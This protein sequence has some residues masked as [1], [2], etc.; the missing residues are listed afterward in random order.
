ML[1]IKKIIKKIK[2][3]HEKNKTPAFSY[4]RVSTE[5]Q[6]KGFSLDDQKEQAEQYAKRKDLE[7]VHAFTIA[8]S[9]RKDSRKVF[10]QM[11]ELVLQLDVK[12][13]IFK[14]TDRMSRNYADL[15]KIEKMVDEQGLNVHFY[16]NDLTIN[17][18]SNHNARFVL[19]IETAVAKQLSDKISH[20]VQRSYQHRIEKGI[21]PGP[22]PFGY[23]Y[24]KEKKEYEKDSTREI[25]Q[26]IHDRFDLGDLSLSGMVE[27]LS[28]K[29]IKSPT[30]KK[31]TKGQV[32]KFLTNPTYAGKFVC[33]GIHQ[34]QHEPYISENRFQERLLR[35]QQSFV[36]ERKQA[37]HYSFSALLRCGLCDKVLTGI[38]KKEKHVYYA[39][40]H[41]DIYSY[42]QEKIWNMI[43]KFI[44]NLKM[45]KGWTEEL[46]ALVTKSLQEKSKNRECE[47]REI[48][49]KINQLEVD[50]KKILDLYLTEGI[51]LSLLKGKMSDIKQEI[52]M[53]EKRK[54]LVRVDN[55]KVTFQICDLIDTF[56][57]MPE[58]YSSGTKKEKEQ[59]IRSFFD[60]IIVYPNEVKVVW[61]KPFNYIYQVPE[62]V[63]ERHVMGAF[64]D[65]TGTIEAFI[66][67]MKSFLI[68]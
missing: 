17:A 36:G 27:E 44:A 67:E 10:N 60:K 52:T 5:D 2:R 58:I 38:I 12:N 18:K 7:I 66:Y 37:R 31:W 26:F 45:K 65:E 43:D 8:E 22:A 32:H 19:A 11:L 1:D 59:V 6:T 57:E 47:L 23:K 33:N 15:F 50:N 3:A 51:D 20:D 30:G 24:N 56:R 35:L 55:E 16:Q 49:K 54:A 46:K 41:C 68:A 29:G 39:H 9:A 28:Q 21:P 25:V 40:Q 48:N 4:D 64:T 34:G 61:K 14:N 53:L 62:K 63:P 42:T 13:I